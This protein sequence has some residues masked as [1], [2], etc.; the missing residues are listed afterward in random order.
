MCGIV[1]ILSSKKI[2]REQITLLTAKLSHRGP[3]AQG[4]YLNDSETVAF[5]HT[6]L[7]IIDLSIE[8]NQPFF[9]SNGR[10]VIV[11]NGEI[12]NYQDIRKELESKEIQFRTNSDTE[13]IIEGFAYWGTGIV[14]RLAGM[15]A[16]AI[17]DL[18]EKRIFFARDRIG[19]KPFYYFLND[20]LFAFAS[21][22]KSLLELDQ[23]QKSSSFKKEMIST[24][25]QLGYIPEPN[26]IYNHIYK[27]PA[28]HFASISAEHDLS[29]QAYW[30]VR[31][32]IHDKI[33]SSEKEV[34]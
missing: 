29:I 11:Y 18:S 6:R 13:V 20:G 33:K 1:G 10:Y 8:A 4:I 23:I 30:E 26:T 12:Y 28:G 15:F 22:I 5:G 3:D 16:F 34:K 2:A 21:E 27:F 19:K 17:Y 9:S 25:L 24:F 31:E 32:Q 14:A 7:S